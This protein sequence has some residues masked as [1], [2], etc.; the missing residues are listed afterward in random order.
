[1]VAEFLFETLSLFTPAQSLQDRSH[2]LRC[3]R[4][5]GKPLHEAPQRQTAVLKVVKSRN[6]KVELHAPVHPMS[7]YV[8]G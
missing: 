3:T 1:M 8:S 4:N 6:Q 7:H 2:A 5:K